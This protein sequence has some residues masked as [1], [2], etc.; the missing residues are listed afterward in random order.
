MQPAAALHF[1]H[2]KKMVHRDIKPSNLIISSNGSVKLLDFG[3]TRI[4]EDDEEFS[5]AM[6]FGHQCMGTPDYIAPEQTL[7]SYT[8]DRR[9]DIYSL[10][11]TLYHLL[12]NE[13]PFTAP[14]AREKIAAHRKLKPP[15]VD[16][17]NP[18]VPPRVSAIVHKMLCKQPENRF[19][20]AEELIK[21]LEPLAKREPVEFEFKEILKRR[22]QEDHKRSTY[23]KR[24]SELA[25]NSKVDG[26][27]SHPGSKPESAPGTKK[28]DAKDA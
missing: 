9:A 19:Q 12:C 20:T 28:E 5:M 17:R 7:D 11:C 6:I 14:T 8:V 3:L 18:G 23:L 21:Y 25:K 27:N 26:N 16:Q 22:V 24:L 10:G 1:M 13:V 4:D 15:K 2:E